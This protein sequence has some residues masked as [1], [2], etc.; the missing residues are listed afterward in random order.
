MTHLQPSPTPLFDRV[1]TIIETAKSNAVR[2]IDNNM[3]QAY[4]SIG[5]EIVEDIQKGEERA[6]YGKQVII[7]LSQKL[8]KRYNK[9]YSETNLKYFRSFYLCF[10]NRELG[11]GHPLGDELAPFDS[12]A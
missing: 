4:W 9:G 1:I 7:V 8:N 3:V 6:G 10:S 2:A 5:K 11:K 12:S